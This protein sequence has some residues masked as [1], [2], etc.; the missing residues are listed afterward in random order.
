MVRSGMGTMPSSDM[1]ISRM[2][3]V[4]VQNQ[5]EDHFS[6]EKEVQATERRL[7]GKEAESSSQSQ[8]QFQEAMKAEELEERPPEIQ[9]GQCTRSSKVCKVDLDQEE[10]MGLYKFWDPQSMSAI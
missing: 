10:E 5:R 1:E 6:L 3:R 8:M 7:T 9:N 4:Q 2:G